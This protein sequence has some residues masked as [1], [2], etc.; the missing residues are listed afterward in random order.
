VKFLIKHP[1]YVACGGQTALFWVGSDRPA[2]DPL[3]GKRVEWKAH[4]GDRSND[5][6]TARARLRNLYLGDSETCY[7]LVKRT[8][9]LQ[10]QFRVLRDL[11]IQDLFL[12]EILI[13]FLT[14]ISGRI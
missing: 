3:Y 4:R 11:G 10:A 5:G 1:G 12:M 6:E 8:D 7:Y 14:A 9:L 2:E 13:Y